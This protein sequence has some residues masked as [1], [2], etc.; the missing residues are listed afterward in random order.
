[1]IL[2]PL[3]NIINNDLFQLFD[4]FLTYDFLVTKKKTKRSQIYENKIII[5]ILNEIVYFVYKLYNAI[6]IHL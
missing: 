4:Q 5:F 3:K 2:H 1:M 6:Y